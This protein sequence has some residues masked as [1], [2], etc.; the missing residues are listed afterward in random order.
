VKLLE[1]IG[2][3]KQFGKLLAV[4]NLDM[5]IESGELRGLI[6]PNGSGKSTLFNLISGF[7]GATSG[8]VIWQGHDITKKSPDKRT[9]MGITRTFQANVLFQEQ[10]A[11]QN[12]IVACH[13]HLGTNLWQQFLRGPG[14]VV[15]EKAIQKRAL[16]LL[17]SMDMADKADI[18]ANDLPHGYQRRLGIA[19]A[20]ATEPKL[21]MLDEPGAGLNTTEAVDLMDRV[22]KLNEAGITILLV[23][24]NMRSIMSV[25]R[26]ITV[27]NFGEKIAEGTPEEITQNESVIEAYLG[28]RHSQNN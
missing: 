8:K 3:T 22:R 18:V 12:V 14:T 10:T 16:G 13:L 6:G 15:K 9:R 26:K 4:D 24:H 20:L 2:V 28:H 5:S 19:I 11:W 17:E 25:C 21:L 27:I 23:E 1:T 7:Y